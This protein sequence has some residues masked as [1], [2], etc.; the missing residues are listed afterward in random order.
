LPI[1]IAFCITDLDDGGAE[2]QLAELV[3]RLP[4]QRF[5]PA[6]VVLSGAPRF[7]ADTLRQLVEEREITLT[8]LGGRGIRS[9]PLVWWRLRKWLQDFQ[10][11]LL[12][13]FLAHANIL[14]AVVG[15]QCGI[16]HI[17]AGIRVAEH[18][19]GWHVVLQ[20]RVARFV[21]KQV[22]VS[23]AV[24]EFAAQEMRLPRERIVVIPNGI[25]VERFINAP[26]VSL[27]RLGLA[28]NRRMILFAGRLDPQ[29]RPD[30]LIERMPDVFRRLPNHD[31]VV[32]GTGPLKASLRRLAETLGITERVH[33]VG[34]QS[35]MPGLLAAADVVVLTSGWEGMPNI[36]LEAMAAA[37]PVVAT[38]VHGVRELLGDAAGR[39]ITPTDDCLL[40]VKA[41][42]EICSDSILARELG[43]RNLN[44]AKKRFSMDA[45][46]TRYADLYD[47]LAGS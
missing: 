23:Y 8:F 39:Q 22:C 46:V 7:P 26:P 21:E 44:L 1:R 15:H 2:R 36:V 41:V 42:A 43:R 20:R 10:P 24:A 17:V 34:W 33:F 25:N 6:V 9:T 47:S 31:L 11:A 32:A 4:R 28:P 13:C 19:S 3:T 5:E 37:R 27:G 16:G 18:R 40:F 35:D 38:D 12:Q 14:G 45:M 29:K 30:W